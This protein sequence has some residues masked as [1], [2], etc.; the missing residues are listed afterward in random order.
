MEVWCEAAAPLTRM[1]YQS[2]MKKVQR[3]AMRIASPEALAF[4]SEFKKEWFL[5]N[6]F[7]F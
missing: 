2:E 5:V 3:V 4:A 7:Y 6:L 1:Q